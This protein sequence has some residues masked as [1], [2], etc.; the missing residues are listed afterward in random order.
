MED[1]PRSIAAARRARRRRSPIERLT[2]HH[3]TALMRWKATQ[4]RQWKSA[5]RDCWQTGKYG[6]LPPDDVALLQQVRNI[7]GPPG[8]SRI[9]LE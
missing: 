5:L 7:I 9:N 4:G 3:V 6:A 8:L 2:V 1:R